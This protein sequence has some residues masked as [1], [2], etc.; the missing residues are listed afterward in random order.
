[1]HRGL[2]EQGFAE[3]RNCKIEYRW[4]NA[5]VERYPALA[6]DL[7]RDQVT[8]IASLGGIPSAKAAKSA[9]TTIP[10]VFQGGF[11][12]VELGLVASLVQQ[13][14]AGIVLGVGQ[15]FTGNGER[16]GELAARRSIPAIF[17]FR[18]FVESGGLV[19]YS[20]NRAEAF[21]LVGVYIG[22]ILKG[23]KPAD[24]PV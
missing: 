16:L 24:L 15:P 4:A 18:E 23:E 12:P 10:V 6:A 17:E 5:R 21:R 8:V 14:S 3:G 1:F 9:T 20:G 11:D 13:G 7:V 2:A 22:R 19:S